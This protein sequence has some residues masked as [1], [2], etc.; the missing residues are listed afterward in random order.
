MTEKP[1]NVL[2][3]CTGNSARSILAEAILNKIGSGNF[4]AFSAGSQSKGQVNP[5][6]IQLLQSLGYDTSAFRSKSWAEFAKPGA[7]SLD[8]VFTVCDNAAG[9]TCPVWPG[10]PMTAHWGV[11]DPAEAKGS[12]AEIALAFK[13]AYRMLHQ[14]IG[15]FAALPIRSLDK[16]SLQT[17]LKEIG[18]LKD[19][20]AKE[21]T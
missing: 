8:F 20:V 10:Q 7:P 1:F 4:R 2:F 21:S 5:N 14:R 18:R 15:I 9:E 3:L 6:T 19:A 13:D 17:K 16:L 11:P 12:E